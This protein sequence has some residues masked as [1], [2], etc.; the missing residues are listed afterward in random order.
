MPYASQRKH[1]LG[2]KSK[3]FACKIFWWPTSKSC[4]CLFT[5]SCKKGQ[6]LEGLAKQ[7]KGGWHPPFFFTSDITYKILPFRSQCPEIQ[8]TNTKITKYKMEDVHLQKLYPHHMTKRQAVI[9]SWEPFLHILLLN[10]NDTVLGHC[11]TALGHYHCANRLTLCW[12]Y[13][14]ALGHCHFSKTLGH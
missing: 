9:G 10:T 7:W 2:K 11:H 13:Y 14:A 1:H 5:V 12:D 3:C 4:P 6:L 8:N